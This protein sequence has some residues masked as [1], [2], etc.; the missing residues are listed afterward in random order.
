MNRPLV[1]LHVPRRI[2]A[3][4]TFAKSVAAAM[5]NNPALPS[6]TFP[7]AT[8]QA[9]LLA[10]DT[11]NAL[12]LTRTKG[13]AEAR[14]DKLAVVR[15]DLDYLRAYVQ[16]VADANPTEA[17]A[18]IERAGMSVQKPSVHT[19]G[20]LVA[21]QGAVSGSVRLVAKSAGD[22]AS[23]DWQ[24]GTDA[25]SWTVALPTLQAKTD[26]EGLTP[27]TLYY[28]RVRSLTKAGVGDFSQVVSLVVA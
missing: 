14:D 24:Y 12:V 4:L 26:I 23:Y 11:A 28:F 2:G 27:A 22:R 1:A 9:D 5:T 16:Q 15:A 8:L 18:I 3:I 21:K 13:A 10:L 7:I 6:P 25:K 17:E 19:K 20:E